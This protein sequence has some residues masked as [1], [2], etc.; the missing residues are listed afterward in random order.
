MATSL[1]ALPKA[2]L[3]LHLEGAMRFDT[4]CDLSAKHGLGM[5]TDTRG[6]QFQD[7]S[8]FVDTYMRACGLIPQRRERQELRRREAANA[9]TGSE[10]ETQQAT[11]RR[12]EMCT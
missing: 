2:E 8:G 1:K 11:E 9:A 12:S 7:F 5:V 10:T 3:H 4:L 6:V